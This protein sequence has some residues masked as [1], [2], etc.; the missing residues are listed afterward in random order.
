MP[1]P[2]F[3]GSFCRNNRANSKGP[4]SGP[5]RLFRVKSKELRFPRRTN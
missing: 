5:L 2:G 1:R 4:A 3:G